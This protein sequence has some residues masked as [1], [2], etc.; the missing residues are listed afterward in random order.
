MRYTQ[1]AKYVFLILA[2][3]FVQLAQADL[4]DGDFHT[5]LSFTS[6]FFWRGVLEIGRKP[7][8]SIERRL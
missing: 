8:L 1:R 4:T 6:D 2:I 5:T 3:G 7:V